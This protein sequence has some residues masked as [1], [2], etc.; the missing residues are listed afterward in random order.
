MITKSKLLIKEILT[1]LVARLLLSYIPVI[2]VLFPIPGISQESQSDIPYKVEKGVIY[3]EKGI[4]ETPRWF[5]DSRVA[6]GYDANCI[7]QVDYYNSTSKNG[8]NTVFVRQ[9]WDG[10]RYYVEQNA[11]THKPVYQRSKIWPFGI[12]SEWDFKGVV[13]KHRIMAIDEAIVLQLI[14]PENAPSDLHFKMEFYENFG[15]S[16]SYRDDLRCFD[17]TL[18]RKW[19]PWEFISESNILQGNYTDQSSDPAKNAGLL[20]GIGANFKMEHE[21]TPTNPKHILRSPVLEAG[22]T[23]SFVI[24]FNPSKKILLENSQALISK[25]NTS[26]EE[27]ITRY[28]KVAEKCPELISPYPELNNLVSLIPVYHEALKVKGIPGAMR[29][30]TTNYWVWGWDGMT[31]NNATAYWGDLEH[32]KNMLDFYEATADPEKGIA[33]A[34]NND[35]SVPQFSPL[36]AQGM[37]I[38]LLQLYYSQSGDLAE[39]KKHYGFAKKIFNRIAQSE[40]SGLGLCEGT[41]LFPDFINHIQETGHDLSSFNNTLFYS[42]VR[43]M[44]YLSAKVGDQEQQDQAAAYA[45]K[46]ESN[47]IK[48]FFDPQKNFVVNSIDSKTLNKRFTYTAGAIRWENNYIRDLVNP[49]I[50]KSLDFYEKNLIAQTGIRLVPIWSG[51]YDK[52][53]NQLHCWWPATNEYYSRLVNLNNR[54]D[55]TEQWIGWLSYWSKHL[56]VPEAVSCYAETSEP[57]FDRWNSIKGSWQAF[58]MRPWYQAIIHGL[59]GVDTEAGGITFYPYSGKEMTLKGLNYMGKKFDIEMTGSGPFIDIIDAEG[60]LIKGTNKFPVDLYANKSR[61]TIRVHRVETNPYPVNILY[62]TG[63]ELSKY[64]STNGTINAMLEGAGLS[65]LNIYALKMPTVKVD[66]KKVKVNFDQEKHQ[67]SIDLEMTPNQL[68]AVQINP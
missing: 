28:K 33:H 46:I 44:E 63:I 8:A 14:V 32:I 43:S 18:T 4:P 25:L 40:A 21:R 31:C 39:I 23:Y 27:Q 13:I 12:E 38:T 51:S 22:K 1:T 3:C 41:S 16:Y 47:Y 30:K 34:Y 59:V 54:I 7:T 57:E 55:L 36:P 67:A 20:I 42:A 61:L 48:L 37:Y 10:F 35:L 45:R 19:K 26:I 56:T 58:A 15:L 50:N 66:G 9:L 49:I 29:A 68:K 24:S 64:S 53:A 6:F 17:S 62:G 5:A 52:D 11:T 2:F 65:R 60:T